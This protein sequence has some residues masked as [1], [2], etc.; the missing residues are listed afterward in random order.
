MDPAMRSQLLQ[1][2]DQRSD[3]IAEAWYRAVVGTSYVS[4]STAQI[5]AHFETWTRE[6][7]ESLLADPASRDR[8]EA[9]GEALVQLHLLQPEVLG[10]TSSVLMLGFLTDLAPEQ[11]AVLGPRL[12]LLLECVAT[13]FCR[14]SIGTLLA[15][16]EE[17]RQA[18]ATDLRSATEAL[19][20]AR[21]DLE[22]RVQRRTSELIRANEELRNEIAERKR[23][24]AALQES[25]ERYQIV[26]ELA[27][28]YAFS[29]R[30][31][32][33]GTLA[34][35]W[36][37][38]AHVR[39]TGYTLHE[40]LLGG[41][42][43][44]LVHPDD[45]DKA[46]FVI[47][48]PFAREPRVAEY[49]VITKNGEVRW[50]RNYIYPVWNEAQER[51]ER[52]YGA[53]QD[54]TDQKKAE[55]TLR[56]SEERWRSL[57]ENAPDV[58]L[59]ADRTGKILF[60]NQSPTG[61]D[62]STVVGQ[63]IVGYILP[64]HRAPAREAVARVFQTGQPGYHEVPARLASGEVAWYAARLGPIYRGDEVTAAV[65]IGRD[66]TEQ[67][68]VEELKDN[69]V[70]DV[71]HELRTPLAKLEMGLDLLLETMQK[72]EL[73]RQ[74]IARISGMVKGN[75]KRLRETVETMLDLSIL[76]TGRKVYDMAE[77][78]PAELIADII[79]DMQP[80]VQ[81]KGLALVTELPEEMPTLWGDREKLYRVLANLVDNALKFSEQGDI[82]ISAETRPAELEI[83]VSDNGRG[84]L[85]EN[86]ERVFERFFQEKVRFHGAGMGLAICR[87][88][89]E[90]HGGSIWAE[91]PGRGLGTVVRF[92]LPTWADGE[93]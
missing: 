1:V 93:E 21:D 35:E 68:R 87:T 85:T 92:T 51:V 39:I 86:L 61:I 80:L 2:L 79:A 59:I 82:V 63:N 45:R 57:V 84:I 20:Q 52:V 53:V 30:V 5:R 74:R 3:S 64:E 67:K 90:A 13:G 55:E 62:I 60:M 54:I 71:S 41:P 14:R 66:I 4:L 88:I 27:S 23:A 9:V 49:R 47:P 58:I 34:P 8:A 40:A 18:L 37:T 17:I 46:A 11:A 15:E 72:E 81:A 7:V 6:I 69:L 78:S 42:W 10:R 43:Q 12:A 75:V 33:D 29:V 25:K 36:A 32:P 38:E 48:G 89:V 73:D 26:S 76:E 19:R 44:R 16:Q 91:S 70:R 56:E 24:E 65:L 28:D 77:L 83:A 22:C 50:V 31:E